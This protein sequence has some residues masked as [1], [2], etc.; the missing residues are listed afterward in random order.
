M[1]PTRLT[2]AQARDLPFQDLLEAVDAL[3]EPYAVPSGEMRMEQTA[4]IE[5]TLDELPDIYRWVL[6]LES[7]FDHWTDAFKDQFGQ[8]STEFKQM[9]ERRDA[10]ARMASAAKMRYE[11]ASRLLTKLLEF[12]EEGMPRSRSARAGT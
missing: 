11:G 2:I 10:M 9:R 3:I 5:R 1:A 4:R 7:F 6:Q 8:N 12:S